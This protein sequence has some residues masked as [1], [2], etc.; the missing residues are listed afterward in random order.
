MLCDAALTQ[1]NAML[2]PMSNFWTDCSPNPIAPRQPINIAVGTVASVTLTNEV[3]DFEQGNSTLA[4]VSVT[5]DYITQ[6]FHIDAQQYQQ[7]F[8]LEQIAEINAKNFAL[9][10]W[11]KVL[12]L[13]VNNAAVA[14]GFLVANKVVQTLATLTPATLGS[15]YGL[16]QGSGDKFMLLT[17]QGVG[18]LL[19]TTPAGIFPIAG[20]LGGTKAMGFASIDE[21]TYWVG[22]EANCYG[23]GFMK[24]AIV[25]AAGVPAQPPIA[26][27]MLDQRTIQLD[28]L[29]LTIQFNMWWSNKTRSVWG[30]FD[31]I[32][33]AARGLI[34]HGVTL[35]TA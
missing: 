33:G 30:S 25:I 5:P 12:P 22:A 29:G 2:G 10:I 8:R 6:P 23:F 16:L 17:T 24:E 3:A 7:G 1:F 21:H 32:F 18:K 13:I 20:N 26:G 14:L 15:V 11:S 4:I 28:T 35:V 31:V 9:S 19:Y 34:T 27:V